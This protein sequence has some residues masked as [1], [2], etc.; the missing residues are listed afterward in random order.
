MTKLYIATPMYGGQCTGYY[1]R[2]MLGA[3]PALFYADIPVTT[4][5]V[6]NESL[7]TRARNTLA[8]LFLESDATHLMFIDADIEFH[9]NS[10]V[11]M[12]KAD[13]DIICGIY[14]KKHLNWNSVEAAAK[15]GVPAKDLNKYTGL[16]VAQ[17]LDGG[18][19]AEVNLGEPLEIANGGTGFMLIKR[20]VFEKLS[21]KV[22][23]YINDVA[24]AG[25][26]AYG[27]EIKEFF[28]THIADKRLY[29][30]DY[31]FCRLARE[32]GFKIHAAP[33]VKLGHF[34]TYLYEGEIVAS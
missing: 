19:N 1:T 15:N 9:P 8:H 32:N 14:P 12:L 24:D 21:D 2:S 17:L 25:L 6:F 18:E 5:F 31:Q 13:K 10:I 3:I 26:G 16:F 29:S 7:I 30:E 33:W 28:Y 20:E 27:T 23:T 34:G 4:R 22:N 11:E